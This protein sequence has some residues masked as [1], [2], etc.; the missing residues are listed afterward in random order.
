MILVIYLFLVCL[1]LVL[2]HLVRDSNGQV[3]VDGTT[4]IKRCGTSDLSEEDR[5]LADQ[6]LAPYLSPSLRGTEADAA[7]ISVPVYFH[8][9]TDSGGNGDVTDAQLST[10][11]QV[12]NEAH[13]NTSFVFSLR[14][15]FTIL[16]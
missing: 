1:S 15:N 5:A 12:L 2:S 16:S 14:G 10:Q 4:P 8:V 9:I 13:K 6:K 11:I 7:A 3:T